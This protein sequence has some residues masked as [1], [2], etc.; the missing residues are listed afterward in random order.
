M[1]M[2][3]LILPLLSNLHWKDDQGGIRENAVVPDALGEWSTVSTRTFYLHN[4]E[5]VTGSICF[6]FYG[7]GV[8]VIFRTVTAL[9]QY[10]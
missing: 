10:V 7:S 8:I 5:R 9:K 2:R 1:C 4:L 6:L 3:K